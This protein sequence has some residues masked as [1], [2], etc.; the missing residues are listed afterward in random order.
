MAPCQ[1]ERQK[2]IQPHETQRFLIVTAFDLVGGGG[3]K[4]ILDLFSRC[5][6]V[7]LSLSKAISI[8]Y[9]VPPNSK[10]IDVKLIELSL[11]FEIHW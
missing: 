1:T 7:L 2:F 9:E 6:H 10:L 5:L 4:C 11:Q 8:F 3:G